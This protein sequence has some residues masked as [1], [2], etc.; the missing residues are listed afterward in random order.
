MLKRIILTANPVFV[1]LAV[2]VPIGALISANLS[3]S[4]ALLNYVHVLIGGLWTGID[5]FMGFVL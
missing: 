1:I 4:L 3:G 2:F 5:L